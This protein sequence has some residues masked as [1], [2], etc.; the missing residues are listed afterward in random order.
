MSR[1]ETNHPDSPAPYIL[2]LDVG[3]NSIGWAVVDCE[4]EENPKSHKGIYAGYS[5]TSLRALNSRIFL[6]MLDAKTQVPK[7][8]KRRAARGARNRR[9]YYKFRRGKLVE[10]LIETDLLPPAYRDN[11]QATLTEIDREFAER[12]AGKTWSGTWTSTE[13][14]Y[15][16]PYAIRNFA[17]EE[18]LTQHE[19][20]RLLLH[21]QRRRGY[22]SNRGAKYIELIKY[23]NFPVPKDD[24]SAMDVEEKKETGKVLAAIS[25]LGGELNDRTLGQFIWQEA[26]KK[27]IP[28]QRLTLFQ[29]ER[30]RQYQGKTVT[31]RLQ[32]RAQREMYE[33]EFDAIREKQAPCHR[34]TEEQWSVIR[35]L[36]F[37]QR[38]LQLQ[39]GTVGNCTIYPAKKRSALMRLEYQEFRT[40]QVINNLRINGEA[41]TED[42]R[43]QLASLADDPKNLNRLG[44]MSKR[45]I[46][47]S[48]GVIPRSLNY[49]EEEDGLIGNR[50]VLAISNS[51]G[52]DTWARLSA[53]EQI[54]LVEDILTIHNKKALYQRLVDHWGLAPYQLGDKE[55]KEGA[56]NLTMNEQ[57]EDGYG[58]YSLKAV[59]AILPHLREGKDHTAAVAEIG[60]MG[61]E[62]ESEEGKFQLGIHDVPNIAN[63]IVQKAL[64][65]IRR[66]VNAIIKRY[67]KPAIIRM[68]L[69]REMKAS[70]KHRAEI[71]RQQNVNKNRNETAEKEILDF[72]SPQNPNISLEN[73]HSGKKRVSVQDRNKFKMWKFE[74]EEKC[75]YCQNHIGFNELFTSAEIEHIL[76]YTGFRQSYM[77][78]VVSCDTCN[79]EKGKRTPYQAWGHD[80]EIWARI[81]AFADQHYRRDLLPKRKR[82]L[83]RNYQ[84]EDIE[85]FVER[86]LNDTRYIAT[87]S[88]K[89]LEQY[90]VPIDV[91][92]GAATSEVRRHFGLNDVLPKPDISVYDEIVMDTG[93]ILLKFN[94]EK[95]GKNRRDHRHHAIDAFVVAMTD[96]A[97]LKTMTEAHQ[98]VQEK[99]NPS[100]QKTKEEQ[101]KERRLTLL[102]SWR[103]NQ[104]LHSLLQEKLNTTVVSHMVKRKI[105]G[106]LHEGTLYGRSSFEKSLNLENMR[107]PILKRLE[108]IAQANENGTGEWIAD[109][110]LRHKLL[111]WANE[112]RRLPLAKRTLLHW[113]GKELNKLIYRVPCITSR[114]ELDG[115]FLA[116]L[117]ENWEPGTNTWVAEKHLHDVLWAWLK[118]HDLI[119]KTPKEIDSKLTSRPPRMPSKRGDLGPVINRVKIAQAMTDSY[120]KITNSYVKLGNNHHLTL[121]HNGEEG[122][123][124]ERQVNIVT[125]LEAAKRASKG[126]PV[127]DRDAPAEWNGEWYFELALCVN[128]MV[129]CLDLSIFG[130]KPENFA[131]E[132]SLTP[133]FR[134]QNMNSKNEKKIDLSLR[135]HS[136]SGTN[137]KWGVWRIQSLENL[138]VKPVH[139]GNLG[140]LPGDDS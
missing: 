42:Q 84:P 17:Q 22:F 94:R 98:K 7:N 59:K 56:L 80:E 18:E 37:H 41:L 54:D 29:F 4:L 66:V 116:Q 55:D 24:E 110:T 27:Q 35:T 134:I 90:G 118:E 74:Q 133:Y 63:P 3:T 52:R 6:D 9:S 114:K 47:K 127:I 13:K 102:S 117:G 111:D 124:K 103:D 123:K 85:D 108:V 26:I 140:L 95:A 105:W 83:M 113:E 119:D 64:Y 11:P 40:R 97:M 46:A 132:H 10:I 32:F 75:P 48:L 1:K 72:I 50:T 51:I 16:S 68:E 135:H 89:M 78:T 128:D 38:P 79:R 71:E 82:L 12:K 39:K 21:L 28:P 137:D 73:L 99:S 53:H 112:T 115:K 91:N 86:Q 36:I 61:I 45:V 131:D 20:G 14:S 139:F 65:E 88:K 109:E 138:N 87:A 2:G 107:A 104:N 8:Q 126:R 34:L 31:D 136:V 129:K 49:K 67:G 19:L 69:A 122:E 44:R 101:I 77:N 93:E 62:P 106:E 70:K 5:P 30:D 125:M 58:K 23:L 92:N 120:R 121:F 60:K 25:Q 76:P 130:K 43:E 57:L 33:Q 100:D 15:R 81:N 96:R